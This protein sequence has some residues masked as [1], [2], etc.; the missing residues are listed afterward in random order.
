MQRRPPDPRGRPRSRCRRKSRGGS[1]PVVR[2]ASRPP[3][4][5]DGGQGGRGDLQLIARKC[6]AQRAGKRTPLKPLN[7]TH[8]DGFLASVDVG[9][10]H[11]AR[12]I[13]HDREAKRLAVK[14]H[15]RRPV[16]K[17]HLDRRDQH[18][19]LCGRGGCLCPS[20]RREK[21]MERKGGQATARKVKA[22][23]VGG[24]RA[25]GWAYVPTKR[26]GRP[27]CWIHILS[28]SPPR[29]HGMKNRVI[30]RPPSSTV[31]AVPQT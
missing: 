16:A 7:N 10:G 5:G 22:G 27:W 9:P 24:L 26:R 14:L 20:L 4:C 2:C 30:P 12:H 13:E 31:P 3:A 11:A 17:F 6:C 15:L 8:L 28:P 25:R 29:M 19:T 23:I 1:R 18:R 21:G